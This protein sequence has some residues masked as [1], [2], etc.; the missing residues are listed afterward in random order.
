MFMLLEEDIEQVVA[1]FGVNQF[2]DLLID[3]IHNGFVSLAHGQIKHSRRLGFTNDRNLIEW[4][5]VQGAEKD[6]V[7]KIVSY[8]PD[9]PNCHNAPTIGAMIARVDAQS[10]Q[11]VEIADG[12]LLTAMRTGAA[13]AV[14]SRIFASHDSDTV[15]LIGCGLQSITQVHALSRILPLKNVLAFDI[16]HSAL[17][18]LG[19][20]LAFLGLSISFA[21]IDLIEKRSDI[22]CTATTLPVGASPVL[23]GHS[24]LPHVHINAV[25]SD[26]PGKKELPADTVQAAFVVTDCLDQARAEGECQSLTEEQIMSS[27]FTELQVAVSNSAD[28][29]HLRHDKTIFDSTGIA[30]EDAIA[31]KLISKLAR[32]AKIGREFNTAE[33]YIEPKD[34][35]SRILKPVLQKSEIYNF[36]PVS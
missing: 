10:G 1:V 20:R 13:S 18:S 16:D 11:I 24:L 28:F 5:P 12:R 32:Q 27:R 2:M 8:F 22:I 36:F 4:M 21:S 31:L 35:Y 34:P 15:G 6:V 26:F 25:G 30:I 9:N 33:S 19:S 29:Y 14:A 23:N 3:E 17:S 7:I